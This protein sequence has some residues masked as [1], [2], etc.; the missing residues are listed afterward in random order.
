MIGEEHDYVRQRIGEEVVITRAQKPPKI[1]EGEA[2]LRLIEEINERNYAWYDL[3]REEYGNKPIDPDSVVLEEPV[4]RVFEDLIGIGDKLEILRK[5]KS[6]GE[7]PEDI[8]TI[9]ALVASI[10]TRLSAT[11]KAFEENRTVLGS[12]RDELLRGLVGMDHDVRTPFTP[13]RG[14]ID[15]YLTGIR[16]ELDPKTISGRQKRLLDRLDID[17]VRA[18]KVFKDYGNQIVDLILKQNGLSYI[19]LKQL[20]K[21]IEGDLTEAYPKE[22]IRFRRVGQELLPNQVIRMED[23]SRIIGNMVSNTQA[24]GIERNRKGWIPSLPI[25]FVY[26]FWTSLEDGGIPL[27][28]FYGEDTAGGFD[29]RN[30]DEDIFLLK[31]SLRDGGT[32]EG[33][34][35]MGQAVGDN[36]GNIICGN[37]LT[38]NG[39]KRAFWH[40][41]MPALVEHTPW[42][43][44]Y[45]FKER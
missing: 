4:A 29:D 13:L 5:I 25:S 6:I 7:I 43:R 37:R 19:D 30:F 2:D 1:P 10:S 28:N 35:I 39:K 20:T 8:D 38:A 26:G 9:Q 27:V 15:I 18:I 32:G 21:A 36:G 16:K 14:W 41:S 12:K 33:T 23:W 34:S 11:R 44:F 22:E 17:P 3:W 45:T 31:K 24:I 42:G 40:V